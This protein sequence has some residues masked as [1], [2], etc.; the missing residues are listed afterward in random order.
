MDAPAW[1]L[2]A[3]TYAIL[4]RTFIYSGIDSMNDEKGRWK[5]PAKQVWWVRPTEP[6]ATSPETHEDKK[7]DC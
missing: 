5:E 6:Q 7:D 1:T 4:L 3:V 2:C